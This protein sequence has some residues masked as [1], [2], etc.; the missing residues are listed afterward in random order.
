[1]KLLI[2]EYKIQ[3]MNFNDL[4]NHNKL[5]ARKANNE[6]AAGIWE[7]LPNLI[8]IDHKYTQTKIIK[9]S[10]IKKEESNEAKNI[11]MRFCNEAVEYNET[12]PKDN[13][14]KMGI[15]GL[16][17]ET[18]DKKD[19]NKKC[20]KKDKILLL[21]RLSNEII[22]N[23]RDDIKIDKHF[24]SIPV[25]KDKPIINPL[26]EMTYKMLQDQIQY[27]VDKND[28]VT[29]AVLSI[30]LWEKIRLPKTKLYRL[31]IEYKGNFNFIIE[32]LERFNLDVKKTE[33]LKIVPIKE[34]KQINKVISYLIL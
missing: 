13:K 16:I 4:C 32:L 27:F 11:I 14:V 23:K 34:L 20:E 18:Y 6:E 1:M 5:A 31:T 24:E 29:A 21:K 9:E 7:I 3:G 30:V 22:D 15:P 2:K 12:Y 25:I 17:I 8:E 26:D 28:I 33:L 10:S 19:I